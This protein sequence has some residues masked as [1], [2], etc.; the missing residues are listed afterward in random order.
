VERGTACAVFAV[1][2]T[3]AALAVNLVG[4]R[5]EARWLG[6]VGEHTSPVGDAFANLVLPAAILLAGGLFGV[7]RAVVARHRPVRTIG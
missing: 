3:A 1:V 2:F 6:L 4:L 7:A 5:S